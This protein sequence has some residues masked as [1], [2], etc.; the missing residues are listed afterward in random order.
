MK[1]YLLASTA[2]IALT[3]SATAA[4]LAARPN[5]K[6][7]PMAPIFSWTGGYFGF[8]AGYAFDA[9]T[10]FSNTVGDLPNN[11]AALAVGLRPLGTTIKDE[12]FTGGGQIG[13]NYQFG[14][15]TG[16]VVGIEA[17]AAYTDLGRVQTLSNTTNFGPLVTPGAPPTTRVNEY[18]GGLDFLGTVRGR[19]GY[20]FDRLLVYGTGGFAYGSVDDQVTFF[21]PNG[22]IPFFRGRLS[23]IQTGY[24]YGGGIEYAVAS[25]SFFN[26]LNVFNSSAITVKFEYLHYDLGDHRIAIPGV[27]GGP[28]NYSATVRNDGDLVRAGLNFKFGS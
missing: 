11:N 6:A 12:G 28:G 17:D 16:I 24:A 21:I 25:D 9:D 20:A 13:Y 19:V 2:L 26:R 14:A 23:G 7:P 8:N 1:R 22:T 10:R 27:N 18:R 3:A 4:D 5:T 15:G